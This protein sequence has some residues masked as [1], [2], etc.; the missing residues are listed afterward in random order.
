MD[1]II[2]I[3]KE[4]LQKDFSGGAKF[5][6]ILPFL[7]DMIDEEQLEEIFLN[8]S[9]IINHLKKSKDLNVLTYYWDMGG[10][11][12]EKYFIYLNYGF[13]KPKK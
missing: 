9:C 7:F 11:L 10:T 4:I 5:I 1:K 13:K 3:I 2:E 8:S 12:R 6:E